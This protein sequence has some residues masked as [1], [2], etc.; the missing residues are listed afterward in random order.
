MPESVPG[1]FG[2]YLK[3]RCARVASIWGPPTERAA[4]GRR[5]ALAPVG[6][7]SVLL[8]EVEAG[9]VLAAPGGRTDRCR[10]SPRPLLANTYCPKPLKLEA[11]SFGQ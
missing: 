5:R 9:P 8:G 2:Q 1:T 7:D 6:A 10:S 3:P 11:S 4:L